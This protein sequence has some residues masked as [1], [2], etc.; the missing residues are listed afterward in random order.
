[1]KKPDWSLIKKNLKESLESAKEAGK[2]LLKACESE[3][4]EV[5]NPVEGLTPEERLAKVRE[6]IAENP[7]LTAEEIDNLL[8]GVFEPRPAEDEVSKLE[9]NV[10]AAFE[11]LKSVGQDILDSDLIQGLK[12]KIDALV[13]DKDVE[14]LREVLN[15]ESSLN[16]ICAASKE[17]TKKVGTRVKNQLSELLDLGKKEETEEVDPKEPKAEE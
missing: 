2:E 6:M 5:V 13:H 14:Q 8:N 17:F 9:E 4:P 10:K 16:D 11:E 12:A 7:E 3:K 15:M 1:M